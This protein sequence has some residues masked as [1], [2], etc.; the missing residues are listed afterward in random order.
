MNFEKQ[1]LN[2]ELSKKL[3][4]LEVKQNTL[5]TWRRWI[6]KK[7]ST[8]IRGEWSVSLYKGSMNDYELVSAFTA[9]ELLDML[10]NRITLP[11]GETFNSFRLRIE[12]SFT[13]K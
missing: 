9:S 11:E 10:P 5:Y 2:L 3:L 8:Y 1:V 4:T 7:G 12:K 6:P 13:M